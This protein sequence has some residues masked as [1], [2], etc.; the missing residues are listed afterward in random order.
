[1]REISF[2]FGAIRDSI[3]KLSAS[4]MIKESKS[5]TLD[6]F[7]KVVKKIP[8]LQKQ[9]LFYKSIQE[10]K[11][12][13]KERLADRFLNQNLQL[14]INEKWEHI[15]AENKKIRREFLDDM[16]VE[17]RK[18]G[19]LFEAMNVLIEARTKPGFVD[20]ENEQKSYEVVM[21]H[22]LRPVVSES[23][24]SNEKTDAPKLVKDAWKFIT[25][26]AVSNFNDRFEHL[27]ENEKKVFKILV[28]DVETR[29]NYLETIRLETMQLVDKKLEEVKTKYSSDI[30]SINVLSEFK[31][32]LEKM[33][34]VNHTTLDEGIISCI[35]LK[36]LLS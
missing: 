28:S 8:V 15:M 27:N 13:D 21:D 36:E 26:V 30:K 25:K 19:K 14:F 6:S 35:E 31:T 33:K 10:C 16:H 3:M 2:N 18:D 4:E 24:K 22:L 29:V 34:G 20:F 1:M 32:K 7:A 17:A 5:A 11:S 12:F 9:H 23:E